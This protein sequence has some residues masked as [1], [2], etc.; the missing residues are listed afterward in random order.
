MPQKT[1]IATAPNA[2]SVESYHDS[3]PGD[4]YSAVCVTVGDMEFDLAPA[5][6]EEFGAALQA[7]AAS[8]HTPK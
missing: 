3:T 7:H 6:A 8:L 4:E 2:I 5:E 1:I